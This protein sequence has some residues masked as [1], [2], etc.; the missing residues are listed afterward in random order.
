M[1]LITGLIGAL[2]DG[3]FKQSV[4]REGLY[5][6]AGQILVIVMLQLVEY[7]E[8]FIDI[9]ITLPVV[10]IGCGYICIMELGQIIENISIINPELT[11]EFIKNMLSKKQ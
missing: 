3:N 2:K 6:K 11:P 7:G 8:K 5:H 10:S 4:M 1:D 9:G